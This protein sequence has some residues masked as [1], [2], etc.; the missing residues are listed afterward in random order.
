MLAQKLEPHR[1]VVASGRFGNYECNRIAIESAANM[2]TTGGLHANVSLYMS[3]PS[4]IRTGRTHNA[5]ET[6]PHELSY[7]HQTHE[8]LKTC[9][10]IPGVHRP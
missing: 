6:K 5:T 10:E 3:S 9:T 7:N 8:T 2:I 4:N 1:N